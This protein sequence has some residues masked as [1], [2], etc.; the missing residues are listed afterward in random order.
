HQNP[1]VDYFSGLYLRGPTMTRSN[2]DRAF[3]EQVAHQHVP[4]RAYEVGDAA[5]KLIHTI[6]GGFFNEPKYYD[7]NRSPAAFYA[8]LASTGR[9]S[10]VIVDQLGLSEQARE[11]LETAQAVAASA[12]P[13]DLLIIAAWARDP[14]DGLRLRTTPAMLLALSA[15]N[16]L[17]KPF[18]A[19]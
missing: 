10:W 11:V 9:I 16:G 19:R 14:K 5:A 6:G 15:A 7:S 1:L 18:V 17:T 12:R 13:E 4:G 3:E 8:E 2:H